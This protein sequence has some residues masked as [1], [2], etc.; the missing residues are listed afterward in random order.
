MVPA[1]LRYT[2]DHEWVAVMGATG[3][4]GITE[5]AQHELG[6]IVY[7]ELPQPGKTVKAGETMG[8][9]ESVKAVAEIYAPLSGTVVEVNATLNGEPEKV[10]RDPY[11]EGWFCKI[12]LSDVTEVDRLLDAAAYEALIYK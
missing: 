2:R 6:D 4:V 3:T 1:E 11:G 9:V 12:R 5:F 10:N 7:A 8:T